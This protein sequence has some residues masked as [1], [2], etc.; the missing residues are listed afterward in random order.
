MTEVVYRFQGAAFC[1][2][3]FGIDLAPKCPPALTQG[4]LLCSQGDFGEAG[5]AGSPVSALS[6]HQL[7]GEGQGGRFC[8]LPG[9]DRPGL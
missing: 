4:S 6:Q 3:W 2:L 9:P 8:P 1:G 7:W 5:P